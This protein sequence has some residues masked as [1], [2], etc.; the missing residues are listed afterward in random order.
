MVCDQFREHDLAAT[1]ISHINDLVNDGSILVRIEHT[2]KLREIYSLPF[3]P[4]PHRG[5]GGILK[6][7]C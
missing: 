7:R 3:R 5:G 2:H 1:S 4:P 6:L